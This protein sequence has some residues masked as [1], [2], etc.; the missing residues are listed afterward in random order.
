MRA[1]RWVHL[2]AWGVLHLLT[3][4]VGMAIAQT[5]PAATPPQLRLETTQHAAP[6]RRLALDASGHFLLTAGD[7]KTARLW[8]TQTGEL[9]R[10]YRPPIGAGWEG[11]LYGAAFSPQSDRVAVAGDTGA[12]FGL[13]NRIYLMDRHNGR[14]SQVLEATAGAVKRLVWSRDGRHL[15]ACSAQPAELVVYDMA[16]QAP[17]RVGQEALAGDCYGLA[18]G[19]AGELAATQFGARLSVFTLEAGGLRLLAQHTLAGERPLSVAYSPDLTRL[20]VGHAGSRLPVTAEVFQ[21]GPGGALAKLQ[22]LAGRGLSEGSLYNLAWSQSG[23]WLYGAGNGYRGN[24][25][26]V[27]R[28]WSTQDWQHTDFPVASNSLGDV[29]AADDDGAVFGGADGNWGVI[30]GAGELY[31]RE[32]ALADLRGAQALKVS[33]DGMVVQ[34]NTRYGGEPSHVDLRQRVIRSGPAPAVRAADTWAFGVNVTQWENFLDPRING[35]AVVLEAGEVSRSVAVMPDRQSVVLGTSLHLRR[36]DTAARPIWQVPVPGEARAVV[37]TADG[38]RLVVALADGSIRWHAARDGALLLS[39]VPHP[40]GVRWVLW[41][42]EGFYDVA[43]GADRVVGWHVNRQINEAADFYPVAQFRHLYHRPDVIDRYLSSWNMATARQ[44]SDAEIAAQA[45][46]PIPAPPPVITQILPPVV[47]LLSPA[48]VRTAGDRLRLQLRVRSDPQAPAQTLRLRVAG[49]EVNVPVDTARL[50]RGEPLNVDVPLPPHD[51][52]VTVVAG[53]RSG[54]SSA[55]A[56]RVERPVPVTPP[57]PPAPP[58]VASPAPAPV[59]AP[60]VAARPPPA[61]RPQVTPPTA[62]PTPAVPQAVATPRV[63]TSPLRPALPEPILREL[64]AKPKLYILAVGVSK[65]ANPDYNNLLLPAKDARD[66]AE[67]ALRQRQAALYR[68]VEV[69]VLADQEATRANVLQGLEW[70]RKNVGSSDTAM[71]FLA[72]HGVTLIDRSYYFLPHDAHVDRLQ[73]TA[74]ANSQLTRLIAGIK[75]QRLFFIDTC[76]AGNALGGRRFSTEVAYLLN[77]LTA[78]ENAVIVYSSSTGKQLS[79]EKD[80]WGNGAFTKVLVDGING[81]A[82]LRNTGRITQKGLDFYLADEV[83][84]L[85]RGL[86]TPLT[87][88]PFGTPDFPIFERV[89]T[90]ADAS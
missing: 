68:D 88:I 77:D 37:P 28:R 8:S 29:A 35:T 56:V 65:Y 34:W 24:N 57:P 90:A 51:A 14:M 41:Q 2:G 53:N 71:L 40:D 21:V 22:S 1:L 15:A 64:T 81:G 47:D 85:T 18:F 83:P 39:F 45:L 48:E 12:G 26:F 63:V 19:P 23:R 70:L 11:R 16:G 38:E 44:A 49:V 31:R 54:F 43:P 13:R 72:G 60:P 69:R 33:A 17:R 27:L 4:A 62:P 46:Q 30:N 80:A 25:E 59:P 73:Q 55:V 67:T 87:I 10:V 20:A 79:V 32:S 78:D 7:D 61:P 74:I 76:H 50:Q 84:K 89:K 86:Q 82:D 36:L 9:L 66:F 75:G 52:V 5:Q 42:A 3:G 6:V 58:V